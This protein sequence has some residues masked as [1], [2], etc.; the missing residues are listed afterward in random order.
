MNPQT[1]GIVVTELDSVRLEALVR[2]LDPAAN[3][4]VSA[5]LD[6]LLAEATVVPGPDVPK[7]TVTMNS[8]VLLHD[9]ETGAMRKV[10]LCY[11]PDSR[12]SAGWVSVLSPL[13]M[14]LPGRRGT[15]GADH[16]AALP[17]GVARRLRHVVARSTAPGRAADPL[18]QDEAARSGLRTADASLRL[19]ALALERSPA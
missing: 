18:R 15:A 2:R 4:A 3:D 14:G 12:P 6:E 7:H 13:G 5:R 17:A 8:R 19:R 1:E 10:T 9:S 16:R 11:P